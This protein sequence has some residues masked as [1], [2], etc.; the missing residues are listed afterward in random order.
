[1][2]SEQ[3]QPL[4]VPDTYSTSSNNV[5]D[6]G[7]Y[8]EIV[9]ENKTTWESTEKINQQIA[10]Q[11]YSNE[12][13]ELTNSGGTPYSFPS[14]RGSAFSVQDGLANISFVPGSFGGMSASIAY[15]RYWSRNGTQQRIET[16]DTDHGKTPVVSSTGSEIKKEVEK[17]TSSPKTT[18]ALAPNQSNLGL[19]PRQPVPVPSN[20]DLVESKEKESAKE[21]NKKEKPVTLLDKLKKVFSANPGS[22]AVPDWQKSSYTPPS[23]PDP[24]GAVWQFL[25]NPEELQLSTGPDYNRSDS[26]GVSD[27]KN[28]GQALSWRSNKNRKL[29]F[30]R[31][32]L[33]GYTFGK[34]VDRLEKGL[35]D[36]FMARDGENGAD[37]PPVLEFVW[38]DRVF[39]PCVIQN[40]QVREKAW[41]KGIL[42]NAEVSF[43]LE[44]VPEWTINDGFVD[45]LRP[46]RQ[47][48]VNDPIA[49]PAATQ[50]GDGE[51]NG[52]GDETPPG[53]TP[54]GKNRNNQS[55]Q[56]RCDTLNENIER[57][58]KYI[59]KFEL[60]LTPF[61]MPFLL[62]SERITRDINLISG[63]I[64]DGY[65]LYYSWKKLSE[66]V[67]SKITKKCRRGKR[68]NNGRSEL[69][70]EFFNKENGRIG[71][72]A[73][74]K[75][76]KNFQNEPDAYRLEVM[77]S[78]QY[79]LGC[80]KETLKVLQTV[81]NSGLP[82][83]GD[84]C[85]NQRVR[86]NIKT[87]KDKCKAYIKGT[88]SCSQDRSEI[89]LS[90]RDGKPNCEKSNGE[91]VVMICE[92]GKWRQKLS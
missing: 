63:Y 28:E 38:G 80:A 32:L 19:K 73:V 43:E 52:E 4:N 16:G 30:G 85:Y 13:K 88:E 46:G 70:E 91:K 81:R 76:D 24:N 92:N 67:D 51:D 6:S 14:R 10:T 39:G 9:K 2:A 27:P 47:P 87:N 36:L 68:Q 90:G 17:N 49:P 84:I 72:N 12:Y 86:G 42:V 56:A 45:V 15:I 61:S 75:F 57:V 22:V 74:Q 8:T 5:V 89:T 69:N 48:L 66:Y 50:D 71:E 59:E 35:Q 11:Q 44:Q 82:G 1:M 64:D 37:G 65:N 41:D 58:K 34:R 60:S 62:I 29:T 83:E 18:L 54:S 21:Q 3:F 7:K 31:V 20:N 55:N 25:F 77:G 26:W 78:V 53:R 79:S 23:A 33:H 40:I